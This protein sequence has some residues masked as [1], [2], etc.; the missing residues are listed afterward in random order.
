VAG[1]TWRK[2]TPDWAQGVALAFNAIAICKLRVK[3]DMVG[4]GLRRSG[5]EVSIAN[6]GVSR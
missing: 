1:R 3:V 2:L 6:G 5:P 4:I